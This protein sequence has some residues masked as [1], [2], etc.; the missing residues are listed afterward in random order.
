MKIGKETLLITFPL[1]YPR[2]KVC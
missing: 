1:F 2:C